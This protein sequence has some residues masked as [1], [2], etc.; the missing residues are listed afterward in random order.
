MQQQQAPAPQQQQQQQHN[1]FTAQPAQPI[2]QI[3]NKQV[4]VSICLPIFFL[5]GDWGSRVRVGPKGAVVM[6]VVLLS[7]II[8]K[9]EW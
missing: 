7:G 2:Q 8:N 4:V 1:T 6:F 9:C 5:M 3:I